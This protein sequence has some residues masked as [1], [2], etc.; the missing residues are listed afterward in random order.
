MKS[1]FPGEGHKINFFDCDVED[2]QGCCQ[3]EEQRCE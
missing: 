2:L 1:D 3:P